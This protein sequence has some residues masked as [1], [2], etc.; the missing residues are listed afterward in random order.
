MQEVTVIV[1]V[2]RVVLVMTE[3]PL[4]IVWVIGQSVVVV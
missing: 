2:D 1:L 4:V 3:L